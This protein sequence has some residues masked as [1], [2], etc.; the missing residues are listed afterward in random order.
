MFWRDTLYTGK[1]KRLF[2]DADVYF[3]HKVVFF[4]K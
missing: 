4:N 3:P 1:C 2:G